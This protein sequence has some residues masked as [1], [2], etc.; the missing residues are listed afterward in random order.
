[1]R[2][3]GWAWVALLEGKF[4]FNRIAKTRDPR[5]GEQALGKGEPNASPEHVKAQDAGFC[6]V[7]WVVRTRNW[8][9]E[10]RN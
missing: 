7:V 2:V 4:G 6:N 10:T 9:P 8:K 3:S 1:M 5:D